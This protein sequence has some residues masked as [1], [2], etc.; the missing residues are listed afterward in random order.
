MTTTSKKK[1]VAPGKNPY[2]GAIDVLEGEIYDWDDEGDS[3][4]PKSCRAAIE[5]LKREGDKK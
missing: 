3:E 2:A 4:T 5:L 1:K